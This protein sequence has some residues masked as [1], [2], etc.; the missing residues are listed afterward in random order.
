MIIEEIIICFFVRYLSAVDGGHV[1]G[2]G[3][4]T[5]T[6]L[7][8]LEYN[9]LGSSTCWLKVVCGLFC[10]GGS[11]S[12]SQ[13]LTTCERNP[14]PMFSRFT[15]SVEPPSSLSLSHISINKNLHQIYCFIINHSSSYIYAF[16]T[17]QRKKKFRQVMK[18]YIPVMGRSQIPNRKFRL[19]EVEAEAGRW[20]GGGEGVTA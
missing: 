19:A 12:D 13:L 2:G 3:G 17:L 15:Y 1:R 16:V 18:N 10:F 7:Q 11:V 20:L 5:F 6:A 8:K 4:F 9:L 14:E